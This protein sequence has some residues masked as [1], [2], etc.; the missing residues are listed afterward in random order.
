MTDIN[1]R[2]LVKAA[3]WSVPVI[4]VAVSTPLAAASTAPT[5]RSRI[6]FNNSSA[7][8][9]GPNQVGYSTMVQVN[10]VPEPATGVYLR[11]TLKRNGQQVAV[12]EFNFPFIAGYGNAGNIQGTFDGL[13]KGDGSAF[14]VEFFASATNADSIS[15]VGNQTVTPHG[16]WA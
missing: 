11:I 10:D 14:T 9:A 13:Q 15:A 1:R 16:G 2:T 7:F 4:A 3:A 5:T 6:R 12:K 8:A